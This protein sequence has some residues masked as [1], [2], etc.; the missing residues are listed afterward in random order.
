MKWDETT[1]ETVAITQFPP[2]SFSATLV[3]VSAEMA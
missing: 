3:S 2:R 1:T